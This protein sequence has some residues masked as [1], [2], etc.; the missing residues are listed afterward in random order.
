M[1]IG[2]LSDIHGN[3][4]ALQACLDK[5]AG[6]VDDYLCL[7]DIVGYGPDPN[8]CCEVIRSLQCRAVLGN[9]DEAALGRIDLSWF[10]PWAAR[11]AEWTQ[12][13]LSF[14]NRQ[15]LS[16]LPD[17]FESAEFV[18]VHGSLLEYTTE[19][20]TDPWSCRPTM[21]LMR[22]NLCFVGH[23][24]IAEVYMQKVGHQLAG[25]MRLQ[26]GT[27]L[28]IEDGYKYVFNPGSV[29]QPRDGIWLASC[30]VWDTDAR[31]LTLH[32]V[33]YDLEATQEKMRQ[34]GLPEML[35]RRLA[36]GR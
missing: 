4:E 28:H 32:R 13:V 12:E 24:H 17:I 11:A 5:L 23:T 20:I 19:Y 29:G 18:A 30:A 16:S 26:K 2:L 15:W 1:R 34:V 3:L 33:E 21:D 6:L 27:V 8:A 10:N 31:T 35:W 7:G 36:L 9:H 14:P 22:T 25:Q